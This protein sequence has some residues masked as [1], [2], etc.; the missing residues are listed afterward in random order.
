MGFK[1]DSF[2]VLATASCV[3]WGNYLNSLILSYLFKMRTKTMPVS[4]DGCNDKWSSMYTIFRSVL[5][6]Q[7]VKNSFNLYKATL[8]LQLKVNSSMGGLSTR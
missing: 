3:A 1:G 6:I 4:F 2:H 8:I 5:R 7:E